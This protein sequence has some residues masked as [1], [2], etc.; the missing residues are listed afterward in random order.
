MHKNLLRAVSP[1]LFFLALAALP[2]CDP[3]GPPGR[4]EYL[5]RV[6]E[7]TVTVREFNQAFEL[8]K[9]AFPQSLDPGAAGLQEAR[10]KL[11][12][13]MTIELVMLARAEELGL[14]VS[15]DELEAAVASVKADYPPGVFE[16]T[17][18]ESA[19]PVEAWRQRIRTR[20]LMEKLMEQELR[21]KIVVTAE[22]LAAHYDRHYRGKAAGADSQ[23]KFQRLKETIV[24]DLQREKME[25]LYSGWIDSLK[26]KHSV[27]VNQPL[28][29]QI[30]AGGT[31]APEIPAAK[32]APAQ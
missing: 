8:V 26:R 5:V 13:E 10:R 25:A 12:E 3:S 6:G 22:D 16:Q 9:T 29:A 32:P 31:A 27:E 4:G 14:S 23:E 30:Q 24:A 21:E 17:L 2:G 19:V 11:L 7:R 28:W 18:I 1:M 20:L 15:D